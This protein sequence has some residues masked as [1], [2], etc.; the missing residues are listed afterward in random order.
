VS[1]KLWS[2]L[3]KTELLLALLHV[4]PG[5]RTPVQACVSH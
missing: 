4:I 5:S 3:I 1:N 2:N